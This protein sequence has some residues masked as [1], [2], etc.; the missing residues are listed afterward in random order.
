MQDTDV[1]ITL[2]TYNF[3]ILQVPRCHDLQKIHKKFLFSLE[4]FRNKGIL[5]VKIPRFFLSGK[6][7]REILQRLIFQ[8]KMQN[9]NL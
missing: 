6:S 4:F 2:N 1:F 7:E 8:K 5:F 3:F 9:D